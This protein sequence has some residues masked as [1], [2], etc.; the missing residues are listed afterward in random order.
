MQMRH[1]MGPNGIKDPA[2][3]ND[4]PG[5]NPLFQGSAIGKL[6]AS[7]KTHTCTH[8]C[9]HLD[10]RTRAHTLAWSL[11]LPSSSTFP[12]CERARELVARQSVASTCRC[13]YM[14]LY[15]RHS[16]WFCQA[17]GAG[18]RLW[19]EGK[20][21]LSSVAFCSA[22]TDARACVNDSL[23]LRTSAGCRVACYSLQVKCL[24]RHME[25]G[26]L[27]TRG[28]SPEQQEAC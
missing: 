12:Y 8:A 28:N 20:S 6:Q 7:L 11:W 13:L 22:Q 5:W 9:L 15:F 17:D 21:C 4:K 27:T 26:K 14:A 2:L 23:S 3:I 19:G 1:N 18:L 25:Q 10:A 24:W 16:A